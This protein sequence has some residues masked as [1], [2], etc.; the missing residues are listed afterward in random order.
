M[1][2]L[3]VDI[4]RA[5]DELVVYEEGMRFQG[6]AV[7]LGKLRWPELIACERKKDLGLDAY[8]SASSARDGIGKGLAASISAKW[9][10]VSKDAGKARKHFSDL[11][12]LIFV[13]SGKVGN[14]KRI[15]WMNEIHSRY[16]LDLHIISREDI[17]NSL[18]MPENAPL[19]TGFLNI[20]TGG[21]PGQDEVSARI[22]EASLDIASSWATRLKGRPVIALDCVRLNARGAE[23]DESSS[24]ADIRIALSES[25]RIVLEGPA[26][27]GKTTTLIELARQL[28]SRGEWGFL[29][30]LPEWA[31]SG[32]RILEYIEKTPS[33]R[34][35]GIDAGGLA[36][37]QSLEHFCFLLNGWNEVAESSWNQVLRM[38]RGLERN[39]PAAGIIVATRAHHIV[40]PLPGAI[41]LRLLKLRRGQRAEYVRGRLGESG[42]ELRSRLDADPVLDQLTRTPFLLSKVVS[43]FERGVPIPDTKIGI[44]DV[45]IDLLEDTPEHSN[46]LRLAP[47]FG[48]QEH[49]LK[50]LAIEMTRQGTVSLGDAVAR[51]IVR[52]VGND[53]VNRG[54]LSSV[55][56][57]AAVLA[58]LT[59]HHVLERIDYPLVAFRFDHQQIQERYAAIAIQSRLF[60]VAGNGGEAR[61]EFTAEYVNDPAWAEPLRMIAEAL[62]SKSDDTGTQQKK[63]GAG[64]LL[65][66]MALSV[67]LIFAAELARL[68]GDDIGKEVGGA[69]ARRLRE[70][71]A[72][73]D[74]G[75]R[76]CALA[77]ILASGSSDFQ[78]IVVPLLSSDDS[79][80]RRRALWLWP[81]FQLSTLG[82]DWQRRVRDW[83]DEARADFVFVVLRR[84]LVREIVQFAVTDSSTNVKE[85][86]ISGLSWLGA[87]DEVAEVLETMD[88]DSFVRAVRTLDLACVPA[89]VRQRTVEALRRLANAASD[90]W[91]RLRAAMTLR[92]MGKVNLD[93]CLKRILDE[94]PTEKMEDLGYDLLR[95]ALEFLSGPD[96]TWVSSWVVAR[97]ATGALWREHWKAF[98]NGVPRELSEQ[99]LRRLETED[100]DHSSVSRMTAVLKVEASQKLAVRVASKL[101][102]LRAAMVAG[103][104]CSHEPEQAIVRQL[105]TLFRALPANTAIDGLLS[106]VTDPP[107]PIDVRVTT[108]L[109]SR[110]ARPSLK[111][112]TGLPTTLRVA[113]RSY[114]KK[115]VTIV[116]AE[117]DFDGQE[118]ANLASSLA[119]FGAREDMAT[120][121]ALIRADIK[122]MESGFAALQAGDRDARAMGARMSQAR[123]HLSA[124]TLLDPVGGISVLL[125]FLGKP[126]Y[127]VSVARAMVRSVSEQTTPHGEGTSLYSRIWNA[128]DGRLADCTAWMQAKQYAA[129]VADHIKRLTRERKHTEQPGSTYTLISLANALAVLDAERWAPLVLDTLS[130]AGANTDWQRVDTVQC[131]LTSGVVVPTETLVALV[132]E[133]L[134]RGGRYGMREGDKHL[135]VKCLCLLAFVDDPSRG[136]QEAREAMSRAPL[137]PYWFR[138][139]VTALGESRCDVAVDAL[140]E[141]GA[142][143]EALTHYA[144]EWINAVATLDTPNARN[145]LLSFVDPAKNELD[146]DMPA[147][148]VAALSAGIADIANRDTDVANRLHYLADTELPP[149]KRNCLAAVLR[150]IGTPE[151]LMAGIRLIDDRAEPPIPRDTFLHLEDAFVE[152]Q[153]SGRLENTYTLAARTSNDVRATLF[154]MAS[155]DDRRR[156]SALRLLREIELWR[157]DYG[158]P[159]GEP[160]NPAFP[161]CRQWPPT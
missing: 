67:D 160:R 12:A 152:R 106:S 90:P 69:L 27:A 88:T 134:K 144:R 80:V 43:V 123:W 71:Y 38:V 141:L 149:L 132:D 74:E 115:S 138:E 154:E 89:P 7:V 62:S 101:R 105:E 11:G 24:F 75:L 15:Q 95:R 63:L 40:P 96:P 9:E 50:S 57:P 133:I 3:R 29:V 157:L 135:I 21:Q 140:R 14:Q 36:C 97:I 61:S 124:A 117:D 58:V 161:S 104:D 20:P 19:C 22:R 159:L 37:S 2:V 113:M 107:D 59:A 118:K 16:G 42:K 13:T 55:P 25:R 77:A 48:D 60:E 110:I 41:R 34:E 129:A 47:L 73:E 23:T 128:R 86:A 17:V 100:L 85:E 139:V 153:P 54:Q 33:F 44:L 26:G 146:V 148:N 82:S 32:A 93:Q 76:Q 122:R 56:E 155:E 84:R 10:K 137:A 94:L 151:S 8:A 1:V 111:P 143:Q 102:T 51:S 103:P 53:L 91:D 79:Q 70:L 81:E 156:N 87:N 119:Q 28:A 30:D 136:I 46:E 39:F 68:C 45:V 18:M 92:K 125:R 150:A 120:L 109:L 4:E 116:L 121:V 5:L 142:D 108:R 99:L 72:T 145:L 83:S 126:Y 147:P 114:L 65:V 31:G 35:H 64:S 78:D 6:L 98:I 131:L 66:E 158:R 127:T 112:I 52:A 49:Y 130:L